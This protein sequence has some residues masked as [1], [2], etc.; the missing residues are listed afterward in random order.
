MPW[1]GEPNGGRRTEAGS[2][3][4]KLSND[5]PASMAPS[6]RSSF[7]ESWLK[8]GVVS[9]LSHAHIGRRLVDIAAVDPEKLV[10]TERTLAKD[11]SA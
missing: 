8:Q 6:A 10:P 1:P 4:P 7:S 5:S 2:L 3:E 11:L 9:H